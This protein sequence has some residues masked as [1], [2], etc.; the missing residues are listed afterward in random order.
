MHKLFISPEIQR[1]INFR[2][3]S[4]YKSTNLTM[5]IFFSYVVESLLERESVFS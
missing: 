5:T 3:F 2:F 4:T 1:N